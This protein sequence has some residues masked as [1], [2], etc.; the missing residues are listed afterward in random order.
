MMMTDGL[1][2]NGKCSVLSV[3][4]CEVQGSL[5]EEEEV[6]S[7]DKTRT[8]QNYVLST[9]QHC[10]TNILLFFFLSPHFKHRL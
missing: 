5:N 9:K 10:L 4:G 1:L 7:F 6:L 3:G 2:E 8:K